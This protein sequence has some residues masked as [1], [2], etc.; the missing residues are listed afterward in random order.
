MDK[1]KTF[2]DGLDISIS[3]DTQ[4]NQLNYIYNNLDHLCIKKE[5]DIVDDILKNID[6]KKY[7]ILILLCILTA[8][9][10]YGNKVSYKITFF[11]KTKEHFSTEY[12]EDELN[13]LLHGLDKEYKPYN[14]NLK[15]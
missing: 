8:I 5:F 3:K 11:N 7:D 15:K 10:P 14:F 9:F 12:D 6:I 2:I 1:V 4:D 13:Q